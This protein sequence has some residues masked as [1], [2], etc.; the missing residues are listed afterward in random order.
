MTPK[1]IQK[2]V[3]SSVCV[4]VAPNLHDAPIET[5]T[6]LMIYDGQYRKKQRHAHQTCA[7][8]FVLHHRNPD[9]KY[10]RLLIATNSFMDHCH[11]TE[12]IMIT[13]VT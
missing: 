10:M 6:S 12:D 1:E 2:Q 13:S 7:Y 11:A 8:L 9:S 5:S 4:R 3:D